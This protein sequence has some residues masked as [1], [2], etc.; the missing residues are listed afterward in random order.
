M[1]EAGA[2]GRGQG[3]AGLQRL[4]GEQPGGVRSCQQ[5]VPDLGVV[6][7][8]AGD[9]AVQADA[10]LVEGVI[11]TAL[12]RV[13]DGGELALERCLPVGVT[14][15]LLAEPRH[16]LRP[17][18]PDRDKQVAQRPGDLRQVDGDRP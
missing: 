6:Q 3:A 2:L 10:G 5:P 16:R 14:G 17:L 18:L 15:G 4:L 13:G 8:A 7:D 9:Q 1:G 12:G 11:A